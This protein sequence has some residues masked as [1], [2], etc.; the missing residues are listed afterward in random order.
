MI[1][2]HNDS[3]ATSPRKPARR[4]TYAVALLR[5]IDQQS[6]AVLTALLLGQWLITIFPV[7]D[8][9]ANG[10]YVASACILTPMIAYRAWRFYRWRRHD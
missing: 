5:R 9:F 1:D 3:I 6:T 4:T 2:S 7:R 8:A 10:A